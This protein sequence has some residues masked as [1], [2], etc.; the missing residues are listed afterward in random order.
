MSRETGLFLVSVSR[1]R[2]D[3]MLSKIDKRKEPAAVKR[4]VLVSPLTNDERRLPVL[5]SFHNEVGS[6]RDT[7]H[8]FWTFNTDRRVVSIF[9][10]R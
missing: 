2:S 9:D 3:E 7:D 6:E 8:Q 4:Q 1:S 5:H 10:G